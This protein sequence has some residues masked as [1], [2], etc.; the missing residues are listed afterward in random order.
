M[1]RKER[2]M[3]NRKL[4]LFLTLTLVVSVSGI[5]HAQGTL[6][7]GP[8][9]MQWTFMGVGSSSQIELMPCNDKGCGGTATGT[10]IYPSSGQYTF[11]PLGT[12]TLTLTNA[13]LGEWA[14]SGPPINFY[15]G[16]GPT[17][18]NDL[19]TGTLNLLDLQEAP[20]S[21]TGEFNYTGAANL[22]IRGGSLASAL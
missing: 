8:T 14:I 18:Q 7:L 2:Q 3:A 4:T 19:L 15:Y 10:G 12:L 5:S 13:A 17:G 6:T 21:K 16:P 20:G 1:T 9:S 11:A 22:V